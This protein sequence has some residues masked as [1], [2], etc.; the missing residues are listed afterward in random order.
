ME[1]NFLSRL[2]DERNAVK[3]LYLIFACEY[4]TN[5]TRVVKGAVNSVN[6]QRFRRDRNVNTDNNCDTQLKINKME[7]F[8]HSSDE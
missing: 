3:L 8:V 1:K 2:I 5:D 4:T 6:T 7:I